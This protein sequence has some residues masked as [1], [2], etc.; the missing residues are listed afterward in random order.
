MSEWIA[1]T[2]GEYYYME[3]QHIQGSGGDHFTV[4]VEIDTP[5]NGHINSMREI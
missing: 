3:G 2:A 1:L 4:S 5:G